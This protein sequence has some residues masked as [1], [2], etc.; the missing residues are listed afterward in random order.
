MILPI[1]DQI[2]PIICHILNESLS[3]GIFPKAWKEAQITPL[4]KKPNPTSFSEYR[5]IS[6]L[7]FLSK[8]LKRLIHNQLSEFLTRNELLNPYQS[9]FRPGHSTVTALVHIT[10]AI[11]FGMESG[12]LTVLALLDFSNAFGTV[13]FDI[14]LAILS[15][16]NISPTVVDWFRSYLSGRR[17]R[18]HCEN[19]YSSWCETHVG[20]PQGGVLSPLLFSIFI[21]SISLQLTSSYHLYADDL[22]I[23]TQSS[24]PELTNAIKI[25]NNDLSI[26]SRWSKSHGL[27]VNPSKTQVIV[28]GSSRMCSKVTWSQ[29]PA[30]LFDGAQIPISDT[31]KNLGIL[32]DKNLSWNAQIKEVS[33]KVFASAGSLRR[34]RNFLPT[35]TKT[36]LAQSLLLPILDYADSSYPDLTETQLDKLE[37]LQNFCIRFI[38]GL[39]KY[40]HISEFR[41]KL[42][43]LPIRLRRNTHVLSLLY[44][45]LF[46]P[47]TPTYLKERFEFLGDTHNFSLRSSDNLRLK[48]P[49]HSSSFFDNS[50]T[51]QAVR[52]WNALPDAVRSAPTLNCFKRMVKEHYL[53]A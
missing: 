43:W 35:A 24:L 48:M 46:N 22:Q 36:A 13:D 26:L 27:R 2:L 18:I 50:F 31:V 20:V 15:S 41:T 17:Q 42:K 44:C 39:R 47:H 7:P 53:S 9:G 21:N 51:V 19:A 32:I 3:S 6:I 37:R 11:R 45:T 34:L 8:V 49:V 38:F 1:L 5:P 30:I 4:P 28:V 14:L 16:I 40:D 10:D 23:Y 25:L 33:R 52:L 12:K 29:L